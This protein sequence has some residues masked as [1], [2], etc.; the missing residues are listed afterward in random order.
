M[1]HLATRWGAAVTTAALIGA[2]RSGDEDTASCLLVGQLA[3]IA[4]H[5]IQRTLNPRLSGHLEVLMW[6]RE[7]LSQWKENIDD[8]RSLDCC[9]LAALGGHLEG[10][11]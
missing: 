6:A 5:V 10:T 8:D 9:A 7:H 4:R 3:D 1:Q 11:L 2:C